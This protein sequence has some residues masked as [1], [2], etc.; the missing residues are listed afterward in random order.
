MARLP[1]QGAP[2]VKLPS[3]GVAPPPCRA[4]G[5]QRGRVRTSWGN[6]DKKGWP[7]GILTQELRPKVFS[8]MTY[9]LRRWNSTSRRTFCGREESNV[10]GA[11]FD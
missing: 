10:E 2:Q 3:S 6:T 4:S 5:T 11:N 1:G 9:V 8:H 7:W